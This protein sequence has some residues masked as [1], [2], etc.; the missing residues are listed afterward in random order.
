MEAMW[1]DHRAAYTAASPA[2][3]EAAGLAKC[4]QCT[5]VVTKQGLT[6]HRHHCEMATPSALPYTAIAPQ[7][8]ADLI[9][10]LSLFNTIP[11]D[12][13]AFARTH[14]V[15]SLPHSFEVMGAAVAVLALLEQERQD[16]LAAG[17]ADR[18]ALATIGM[19]VFCL[20]ITVVKPRKATAPQGAAVTDPAGPQVAVSN[21][22]FRATVGAKAAQWLA[23]DG[24]RGF[25]DM[26]RHRADNPHAALA[27]DTSEARARA[28][29][30][31]QLAVSSG[32]F[33][34]AAT[35]L[36]SDG[37]YPPSPDLHGRAQQLYPAMSASE[38]AAL[39]E[40]VSKAKTFLTT[41]TATSGGGGDVGFTREEIEVTVLGLS[42][43]SAADGL[44]LRALHLKL[45]AGI[46]FGQVIYDLCAGLYLDNLHPRLRDLL[47]SATMIPIV[48]DRQTGSIRPIVLS[49]MFARVLQKTIAT[50][51]VKDA[52]PVL[53]LQIG[54]GTPQAMETAALL[55]R[56]ALLKHPDHVLVQIDFKNA[57]GEIRRS[58]ILRQLLRLKNRALIRMFLSFYAEPTQVRVRG[59]GDPVLVSTGVFQGD[60][61]G[62]LFFALALQPLVDRLAAKEA[63]DAALLLA[64]LDDVATVLAKHKA[65]ELLSGL[66][67]IA[68]ELNLGLSLNEAKTVCFCPGTDLRQA[69]GWQ[70]VGYTIPA[71]SEGVVVLG[72]PI[73]RAEWVRLFALK[74]IDGLNKLLEHLTDLPAQHALLLLRY[75]AASRINYLFRLIAPEL[76]AGAAEAGG[77]VL[78]D[79]FAKILRLPDAATRARLGMDIDRAK[80][81]AALPI[82]LGGLSLTNPLTTSHGCFLAGI[83]DCLPTAKRL[84]R[85][86]FDWFVLHMLHTAPSALVAP[87]FEGLLDGVEYHRNIGLSVSKVKGLFELSSLKKEKAPCDPTKRSAL[88]PF[89]PPDLL[90]MEP[91]LQKRLSTLAYSVAA[92]EL[93]A[94]LDP[95]RKAAMLSKTGPGASAFLYATPSSA[96]LHIRSDPLIVSLRDRTFLP[97]ANVSIPPCPHKKCSK[98]GHGDVEMDDISRGLSH[99]VHG[100]GCCTRH[101]AVVQVIMEMLRGLGISCTPEPLVSDTDGKRGDIGALISGVMFVFDV[102][103]RSPASLG[104]VDRASKEQGYAAKVAQREKTQKYSA[105]CSQK[106]MTFV[107]LLVESNGLVHQDLLDLVKRLA[108][109]AVALPDGIPETTTWTAPNFCAYW[110]QRISIAVQTGTASMSLRTLHKRQLAAASEPMDDLVGSPHLLVP[111]GTAAL[112]VL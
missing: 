75:C 82:R 59:V 99:D 21:N 22:A 57:F 101:N 14:T 97:V 88:F 18:R 109:L 90:N 8:K 46:G 58:Q 40:E 31:A 63:G 61:L 42:T 4:A 36:L 17:D 19:L 1:V 66:Q 60:A 65:R 48:K 69:D 72:T 28:L 87:P 29:M 33:S 112:P 71:L 24:P 91:H 26:I 89:D 78:W 73:G 56:A 111:M 7:A 84:N 9:G 49:S 74:A 43:S 54:V 107:P 105:L 62:P 44:G 47:H 79:A 2:A 92:D 76:S 38:E 30:D 39:A 35:I 83:A 12:T 103:I 70:G 15:L 98:G 41:T 6:Q 27:P 34:K 106:G 93:F 81:A 53:K 13:L 96:A 25:Y 67:G 104:V 85:P 110:L 32:S 100:A 45:L 86:L 20:D 5:K 77:D 80:K 51:A 37:I 102:S 94:G 50:K 108:R 52:Q 3:L 10:S 23:G 55:T 16:A 64:Y 68:D 11:P 95:S